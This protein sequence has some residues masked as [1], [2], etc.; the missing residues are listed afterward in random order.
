MLI[1]ALRNATRRVCVIEQQ[2]GHYQLAYR[3]RRTT[4]LF[5]QSCGMVSS[6]DR[7]NSLGFS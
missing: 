1:D 3:I 2:K 6:R 4:A 7:C 5:W